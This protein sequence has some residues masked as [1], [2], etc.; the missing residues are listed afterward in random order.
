M[1]DQEQEQLLIEKRLENIWVK[2][3]PDSAIV[4]ELFGPTETWQMSLGNYLLL[5]HPV[6]QEWYFFDQLHQTWQASGL[7]PGMGHFV[8]VDG[9]LGAKLNRS[10]PTMMITKKPIKESIID[11]YYLEVEIPD[12]TSKKF[13]LS[14]KVVVGRGGSADLVLPQA[15]VSRAHAT[16]EPTSQGWLLTD[17]NS[18]NGTFVYGLRLT[19]TYLLKVGDVIQVGESRLTLRM[20]SA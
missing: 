7:T 9:H 19:K 15:L 11:R 13:I 4:R 16:L 1:E 17:L 3:V 6:K 12:Q 8:L 18:S 5:L 14:H 2:G 10:V 20:R